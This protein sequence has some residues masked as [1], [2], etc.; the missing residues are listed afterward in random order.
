MP[1]YTAILGLVQPTS[2]GDAGV[3]GDSINNSLTALLDTAIAGAA[4]FSASGA[5]T[6]SNGAANTFRQAIIII[7]GS[8]ATIT[9]TAP[10]RT[11]T[12]IVLNA[13][14]YS[15]IITAG[16]T[17]VTI[18]AG[19]YASIAC[20]GTNF[21]KVASQNGPASF[22]A[23]IATS[24]AAALTGSTGLPLT[25]GVTGTLPVANG[26]TGTT[27][28]TGAGNVVLSTSPTL[29]TP[30]LGTPS[31][32]VATNLTGL[33]LTTGVTGILPVANGGT[34]T[35]T[36]AIVAGT[37]VTVSGT[38]P[39]QT[40]NAASVAGYTGPGATLV[41]TSTT[42]TIPTGR[43]SIKAT[44]VG[45]GAGS[46][47]S[48]SGSAGGTAIIWL[49][50][51]TAGNTLTVTIGAGGTANG[52]SGGTTTLASGTQTISSVTAT[53]GTFTGAG[54]IGSGGTVNIRG[55]GGS[56]S[57]AAAGG[58]SILGGGGNDGNFTA[59]FTP[60]YGAGAG[61]HATSTAGGDGVVLFEY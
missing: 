56:A 44:I 18:I 51:L 58:S 47:A 8:S 16:G 29:V 2:G 33:P 41:T 21:Y 20:N 17:S 26:G 39:N 32:G 42:F 61:Q 49:T 3:W 57:S 11:K 55:Q 12:Y 45:G 19:E 22:T 46:S 10:A 53:G 36:P 23:V 24:V 31:S 14:S 52:G 43:T 40:I 1:A 15:A 38:W 35:A 28:V 27:T 50:G 7:S 9:I 34:A 13:S 30:I 60:G 59:P 54:G 4:T 25:T 5:M 37:N 48:A 6:L